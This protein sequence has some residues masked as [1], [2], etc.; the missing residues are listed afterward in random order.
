MPD[1]TIPDEVRHFPEDGHP[2]KV[3]GLAADLPRG[4]VNDWHAHAR[5]QLL[6]TRSGAVTV[7]TDFGIHVLPPDRALWIPPQIRHAT[8][9]LAPS[10][11]RT[12]YVR[13]DRAS[14]LPTLTT[15][16]NVT[17][18]LRELIVAFMNVPRDYDEG[19]PAGRLVD[20]LLDQVVAAPAA[21][22]RLPIPDDRKLQ[23]L[24]EA[25]RAEPEKPIA[26]K[27]VAR[28]LA[29]SLRT[30]ERRF[31]AETGMSFR[32]WRSKAKMLKALEL[33]SLNLSVAETA[34][35]LGYEGQSAFIAGFK[36]A[37]GTTPGRYFPRGARQ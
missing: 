1:T 12:I 18:L 31:R 29:M 5:G 22:L 36:T 20:V 15:A 9:Y 6:Y 37:F 34:D 23:A 33:L 11:L 4:Y 19:G 10:E 8:R 26:T 28:R 27:D 24:A 3:V 14:G 2:R 32:V 13:T 35:R 25:V 30:F 16:V 17:P 7:A 21:T